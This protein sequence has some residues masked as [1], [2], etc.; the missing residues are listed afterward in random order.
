MSKINQGQELAGESF[1]DLSQRACNLEVYEGAELSQLPP[2]VL[3]RLIPILK[4]KGN[5]NGCEQIQIGFY[6]TLNLLQTPVIPPR[7][8]AVHEQ[9]NWGKQIVEYI[10]EDW[11]KK[12]SIRLLSKETKEAMD[13]FKKLF[14]YFREGERYEAGGDMC[15]FDIIEFV[16]LQR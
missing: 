16:E 12:V 9:F 7:L 11:F 3:H 10:F 6:V 4:Q 2:Y 1:D 8:T 5:G 14:P 15:E 13:I